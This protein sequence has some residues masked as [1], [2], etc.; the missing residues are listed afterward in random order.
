MLLPQYTLWCSVFWWM[1]SVKLLVFLHQTKSQKHWL[2]FAF[3]NA[4]IVQGF[5]QQARGLACGYWIQRGSRF[6]MQPPKDEAVPAPCMGWN[7]TVLSKIKKPD[8]QV[9]RGEKD[10]QWS[11]IWILSLLLLRLLFLP[12]CSIFP[13]LCCDCQKSKF[14]F[15]TK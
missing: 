9:L 12:S 11:D 2:C 3:L 4:T 15:C 8:L 10:F 13:F 14:D 7:E 6:R 5:T 1:L